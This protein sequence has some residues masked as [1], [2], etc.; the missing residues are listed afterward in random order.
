MQNLIKTYI[1]I[2]IIIIKFALKYILLIYLNYNY[3]FIHKAQL[4]FLSKIGIL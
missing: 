4:R 3:I 2:C 1:Y